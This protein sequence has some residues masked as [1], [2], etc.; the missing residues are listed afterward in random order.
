MSRL[1]YFSQGW[2]F[3]LNFTGFFFILNNI[4]WLF[5]FK[6]KPIFLLRKNFGCIFELIVCAFSV[7]DR[8]S[9]PS[10]IS[11]QN[12][13]LGVGSRWRR[14]GGGGSGGAHARHGLPQDALGVGLAAVVKENIVPEIAEFQN[15]WPGSL[16][17]DVNQEFYKVCPSPPAN[18]YWA[19]WAN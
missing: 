11:R 6:K 12:P 7:F 19:N 14:F 4:K 18:P 15:Y 1:F 13:P 8:F 3:F 2:C 5:S 17:W 10:P 9:R 16:Y